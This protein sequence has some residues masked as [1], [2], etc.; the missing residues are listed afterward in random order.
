MTAVVRFDGHAACVCRRNPKIGKS[1]S[2]GVKFLLVDGPQS[3]EKM[4]SQVFEVGTR[5][6]H[7]LKDIVFSVRKT[8]VGKP[9]NH[10][11]Y[12]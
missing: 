4:T 3:T 6:D 11:Y 2:S 5:N 8:T 9:R 10:T 12:P 1:Q 7:G